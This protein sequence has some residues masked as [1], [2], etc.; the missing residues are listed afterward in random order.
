MKS[1][2]NIS[3]HARCR[4]NA[5]AP[6]ISPSETKD[7][8][9]KPESS[10]SNLRR[11]TLPI[12]EQA[13]SFRFSGHQSFSLR[14]S[15]LP[16]AIQQILDDKDPFTDIDHGITSMGLG[17]NMVESLRC[18]IEAFQVATRID[19]KWQL[20]PI[21]AMIFR[22]SSGLDPYLE[23]HT[24]NW[25]LHWLIC[26]NTEYSLFAWECMFNRW[27]TMEFSVSEV[28]EAFR[29][30]SQESSKDASPV[31]LRQHWDVLLHSYRPPR[32]DKG[33]DHLDS[34]L[35]VLGLIR[36]VGERP[37]SHGKWES[38][39]TF[40]VGVKASI[41]QQLFTYFIHDWWN[42]KFPNESTVSFRELT[43]GD[44]SPGRLL[45]MQEREVLSRIEHLARTQPQ[46]FQLT[47]SANMRL[48]QRVSKQD[49]CKALAEAY[50][51]PIFV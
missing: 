24:S 6:E 15:W 25:L 21:G 36:E 23:D 17:K 22:P 43:S 5:G 39:Y 40:D 42:R 14:I 31:T 30:E 41:P 32:G 38:L 13:P 18:W 51:N 11:S 3:A 47:D 12:A 44:H 45:K 49:G 10:M 2:T 29:R 16:K 26:T 28:L 37:N 9:S 33:E 46:V 50:K 34:A 19:G 4:K 1:T 48:L 27:P 35:S 8:C 7:H 20:S